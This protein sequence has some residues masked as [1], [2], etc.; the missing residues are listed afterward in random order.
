MIPD[1]QDIL[2]DFIP[3]FLS[4][5]IVFGKPVPP[6]K[7]KNRLESF[8]ESLSNTC[9]VLKV[10]SPLDGRNKLEELFDLEKLELKFGGTMPDMTRYWPPVCSSDATKLLDDNFLIKN[11][12]IPFSFLEDEHLRVLQN[13]QG[14]VHFEFFRE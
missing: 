12:T 14:K 9:R 4:N 11:K 5:L 2:Q 10:K 6:L 1:L 8:C 13:L 7:I 3:Y